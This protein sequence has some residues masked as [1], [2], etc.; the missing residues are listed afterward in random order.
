MIKYIRDRELEKKII[1]YLVARGAKK[2][3]FFGSYVRGE[4]Y[5]DIDIIVEF[6]KWPDLFDFIKYKL[7]L[8]E[9]TGKRID[10][11]AG[12]ES[13]SKYVMP[14]VINEL[15]EVYER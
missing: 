1:D 11:L 3:E 14:Y 15:K 10:L 12:R 8:E 6:D 9:I 4:E 5:N 13:I 7:D 2:I